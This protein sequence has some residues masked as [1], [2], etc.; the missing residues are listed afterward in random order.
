M[1]DSLHNFHILVYG[2][3]EPVDLPGQPSDWPPDWARTGTNSSH[4]YEQANSSQQCSGLNNLWA[5]AQ[6]QTQQSNIQNYFPC[7]PTTYCHLV[8][9]Y[10]TI[11]IAPFKTLTYF[12]ECDET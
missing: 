5:E 11:Y 1:Q 12:M 3:E 6:K 2:N 4:K 8:C 7:G 9:V 10:R